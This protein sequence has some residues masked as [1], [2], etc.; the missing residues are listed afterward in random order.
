MARTLHI[1]PWDRPLLERAVAHFAADWNG[2]ALDLTDR[3]IV[4]PTRQAG[5][6]LRAAL[7]VHAAARGGAVLA[8]RVLVPEQLLECAMPR[9]AQV[10]TRAQVLLAWVEALRDADFDALREVFPVDPPDRGFGW[11]LRLAGE[12]TRLQ[13]ALAEGGLR[14]AD[15][16]ARAGEGFSE[17]Q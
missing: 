13:A 16:A 4:V 1:L 8:P 17:A 10:A 5:R 6:R 9:E 12:M 15:V 11:A 3:L 14:L 7:A 2:G